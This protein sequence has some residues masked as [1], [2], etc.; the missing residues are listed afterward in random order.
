MPSAVMRTAGSTRRPKFAPPCCDLD[1]GNFDA[2]HLMGLVVNGWPGEPREAF[3][4]LAGGC[5]A[6]T[7]LPRGGAQSR[8]RAV[9]HR[10]SPRRRWRN[11]IA[12]WRCDRGI[13]RRTTIAAMRC[14]RSA[15][16]EEA[17]ADYEI[18]AGAAAR[19]SGSVEQ[20][21]RRAARPRP[22][23]GGAGELPAGDRGAAAILPR[24]ISIAAMLS[25]RSAAISGHW[26]AMTRRSGANPAHGAAL[27]NKSAIFTLLDRYAEALAAAQAAIALDPRHVDA[28][29]NCGVA[30][31]HLGRLDE[32]IAAYDR[33]LARAPRSVA[34]AAQSRRGAARTRPLRRGAGRFR[35]A[36]RHRH[37]RMRMRCAD[38]PRPCGSW[39]AMRRRLPIS[40]VHWRL[41]PTMPG[42][43]AAPLSRRSMSATSGRVERLAA[44]DRARVSR[45]GW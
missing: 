3:R 11:M 17:L 39:D 10:R 15:A 31:Q 38:A 35:P 36:H 23:R 27:A 33:A 30:A 24:P 22:G 19:L 12:R 26:R 25:R 28:L 29:I 2:L 8:S 6:A 5:E 37:P 4:L 42:R 20:S 9:R 32:A 14:A 45:P 18:G 13:R 21:R 41:S 44:R 34:G 43:S 7:A 1:S 16:V 40:S